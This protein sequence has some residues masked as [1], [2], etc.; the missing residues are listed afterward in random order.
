MLLR[1]VFLDVLET[2]RRQGSHLAIVLEDYGFVI[3]IFDLGLID[4]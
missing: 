4:D 3:Q 2:P 1:N